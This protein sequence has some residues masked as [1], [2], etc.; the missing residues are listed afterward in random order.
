MNKTIA[1]IYVGGEKLFA[2]SLAGQAGFTAAR[3]LPMFSER[4]LCRIA[5]TVNKM[6]PDKQFQASENLNS[7]ENQWRATRLGGNLPVECYYTT[8]FMGPGFFT[9]KGLI[10]AGEASLKF[11]VPK[12]Q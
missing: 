10:F 7:F 4:S 2:R 11:K 12:S 9:L 3:F 8:S 6:P 1:K 5:R